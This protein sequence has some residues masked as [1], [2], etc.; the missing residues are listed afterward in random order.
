MDY[1][2]LNQ[3]Y[4]AYGETKEYEPLNRYTAKTFGWMFAGLLVTFLVA[5]TSYITGLVWYVFAVPYAV[6]VL[7]IA[8]V[9]VVLFM[10]AQIH[11]VSVGTARVLFLTY[12]VLNGI[13]FSAYFLI[14]ALP[15]MVFI[16]GATA[17][18]FGIMAAIG[19]TTRADLSNLRNFLM[20]GLVFLLVFWIAAMFINLERFE[21]IA[22]TVGIFIFLVFTAYD[23]QKIRACHQAY[24][25]NPQMAK[26][27]SIFSALQL[28][29]DFINL[30]IYLLRVLGR[31]K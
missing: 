21:M 24:A 27:A 7:G 14:Y 2:N 25:Q 31:R 26:K 18:F 23:T 4:G 20:G 19:Y 1:Q 3:Y 8:E 10:S 28:Y 30:F 11:K 5:M 15:S 17:L 12:S 13:V 22:C 29:L 9:A 6:L 16:F